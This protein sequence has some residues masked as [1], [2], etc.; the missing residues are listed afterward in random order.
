MTEISPV[1]LEISNPEL[2]GL[3]CKELS[4]TES[5]I[6]PDDLEACH[7]LKKRENVIIK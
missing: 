4:L 5:E 6:N 3:I 2:E 7:R 1:L